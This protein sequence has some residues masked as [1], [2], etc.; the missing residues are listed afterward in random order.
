MTPFPG[1]WRTAA[2]VRVTRLPTATVTA[3]G[4]SIVL[5]LN[6]ARI[7]VSIYEIAAGAALREHNIPL[8]VKPMY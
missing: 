6:P 2:P 8:S 1:A 4:Q 5:C 3:T 7:V